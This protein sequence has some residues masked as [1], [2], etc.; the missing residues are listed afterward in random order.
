[1]ANALNEDIEGRYV[2]LAEGAMA[3]QYR[4]IEHRVFFAKGGFGCV[5]YTRG[6]A[7][8]GVTPIDGA[9]F[10]VEGYDI[11]RFATDEEI[12]LVTKKEDSHGPR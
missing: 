4:A 3:P 8:V 11:E 1:M 5:P 12:A 9:K 7:V 6:T 10:R 2:V